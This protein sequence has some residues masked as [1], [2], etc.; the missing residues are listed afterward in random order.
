MNSFQGSLPRCA[1]CVRQLTRSATNGSRLG[2]NVLN[3]QPLRGKKKMAKIQTIKVRL[4]ED[5]DAYGRKGTILSVL[6]GRMRNRWYPTGTAEYLT[7]VELRSLNIGQKTVFERDGSFRRGQSEERAGQ[8]PPV[9][10]PDVDVELLNP[11]RATQI[12][13]TLTPSR[14]TFYRTPI[15]QPQQ[16]QA[17]PE[18][19]S[20]P[21]SRKRTRSASSAADDL[22]AAWTAQEKNPE[23][24]AEDMTKNTAIYGSV[25]TADVAAS[26]RALLADTEQGSRVVLGAE[27]IAFVHERGAGAGDGTTTEDL[28]R[29]KNLG[30]FDVELRIKDASYPVLR[31]V[32][33]MPAEL[34]GG[35]KR[36]AKS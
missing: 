10:V 8:Q 20:S 5:V 6:P 22:S 34:A 3:Q 24:A 36:A 33:V 27:D 12:L 17:Q 35:E 19:E 21:A 15:A 29:V 18:P 23:A 25:S 4:L 28:D 7:P 31:K 30:E 11:E 14:L 13:S 26:V 16:P 1:S 9:D 32:V 2:Q